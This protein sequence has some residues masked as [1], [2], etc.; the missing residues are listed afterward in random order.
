MRTHALFAFKV[1]LNLNCLHLVCYVAIF[2]LKLSWVLFSVSLCI[3]RAVVY[4]Y[5][6][7]HK[8]WIDYVFS[9]LF[10]RQTSSESTWIFGRYWA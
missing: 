9:S 5:T 1:L 6:K 2:L 8:N 3:S 10:F 7:Y 4:Y